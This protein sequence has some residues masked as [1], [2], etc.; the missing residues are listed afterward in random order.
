MASAMK[1]QQQ[2]YDDDDYY[3][4]DQD[5]LLPTRQNTQQNTQQNTRQITQELNDR[6]TREKELPPDP[7]QTADAR[8][9][10][11]D[12]VPGRQQ[13]PMP[14]DNQGIRRRVTEPVPRV[15][16]ADEDE[17]IPPPPTRGKSIG[18]RLLGRKEADDGS[19]A[20]NQAAVRRKAERADSFSSAS[21]DS[22]HIS[23]M[24]FKRPEDMV[25][26]DGL[27]QPPQ[28]LD[29]WK[30]GTVGS[31]SGNFLDLQDG[32]FPEPDT[33]QAWWEQDKSKGYSARPRKAE[34]FDGEYNEQCKFGL[35]SSPIH[36]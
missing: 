26:G 3:Y 28:W 2:Q 16:Y 4:D 7:P 32:H 23:N 24:V 33:H 1:P 22:H 36:V 5:D 11:V 34:A 29:E 6:F 18:T 8:R 21:S 13:I 17:F 31:L 14:G 20:Q 9:P 12:F 15:Q 27:Y 19:H 30:K 25:P 35:M 10:S